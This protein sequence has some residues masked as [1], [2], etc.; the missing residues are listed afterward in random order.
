MEWLYKALNKN[1]LVHA[2]IFHEDKRVKNYYK[3]P[4]S[5][6]ITIDYKTYIIN[7]KDFFID[8]EGFPTY[9][10][11]V[12]STEPLDPFNGTK[13]LLSPDYYNTAINSH[14]AR[15]IFESTHKGMDTAML[16]LLVSFLA[17]LAAAAAAY[18]TFSNGEDF[19][20]RLNEIREVL[21]TIGGV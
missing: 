16:S 6:H 5:G 11:R 1:K 4:V 7:D 2:I 19:I 9:T 3:V 21:R 8:K 18:F 17:F 20:Q 13:S 12:D 10:Y 14:V 15:D